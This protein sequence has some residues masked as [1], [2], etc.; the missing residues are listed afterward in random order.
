MSK[1]LIVYTTRTGETRKI[2]KYIAEGIRFT[3]VDAEVVDVNKIKNE[4]DLEGYE[5]HVF[6]SP[7]Y[8]GEMMQS[9]KTML[10]MAEKTKLE[11]KVGGAFG[12]FGWSGEAPER[13]YGTMKKIFKMD[14]VGD[15]LR[16]KSASSTGEM[17]MAQSYGQE[18]GRKI[19]KQREK[20]RAV[21][22]KNRE[23][24]LKKA[25]EME[26]EGKKFYLQV[27][28]KAKSL[29]AGRIFE[30][31]A[32]EEDLHIKK[33][34]EVFNKLKEKKP[35]EK[36]ITSVGDP[37]KMEK[38]F[39]ESLTEKA[40]ASTDDLEALNFALEREDK[41]VRYYET[42]SQQT[43]DSLERRFYLTLSYE[44][45][46][47]YLRILDAIEYLTDPI[48]WFRIKEKSGLNGG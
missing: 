7:T 42:L 9:M 10:F 27:A 3:G 21:N 16:I 35:L 20:E 5:A 22:W 43:D 12:A 6:G 2:A 30:E 33:I 38:V 47:H 11:G 41:S 26:E 28:E 17:T 4:T 36:R 15:C 46:G 1:A 31:L 37:E 25:I 8:H 13:I 34:K 48:G 24:S 45:R 39:K 29:L 23:E 14:M 19:R 44:E 40:A 32:K 18:I